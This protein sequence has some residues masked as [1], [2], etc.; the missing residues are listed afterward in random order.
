[1][2]GRRSC[3]DRRL[4]VDRA[5]RPRPLRRP[6]PVH[7]ARA[8]VRGHQPAHVGRAAALARVG[9][10]RRAAELPGVAAAR[11]VRADA[12]GEALLPVVHEMRASATSGSAAGCT[13]RSRRS[14]S[15]DARIS[16]APS[17]LNPAASQPVAVTP[18]VPSP[19]RGLGNGSADARS[20]ARRCASRPTRYRALG[21][22]AMRAMLHRARDDVG[23]DAGA[24]LQGRPNGTWRSA[25]RRGPSRRA[26]GPS[27]IAS[28]WSAP[29]VQIAVFT[30]AG[31]TIDTVMPQG[32]SS[33]RRTSANASSA[34][35]EART[36]RGTGARCGLR[37]SP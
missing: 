11:R 27:R 31:S 34:C 6:T 15:A 10:D 22:E 29:F 37:R 3:R 16:I 24:A 18:S 7:R 17:S 33:I 4:E 28:P 14:S 32:A 9:G 2:F 26:S 25:R 30:L 36:G 8:L 19:G 5:H 12:K 13:A 20:T 23:V 1:M 35:F 21:R